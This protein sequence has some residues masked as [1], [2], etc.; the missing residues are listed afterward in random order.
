MVASRTLTDPTSNPSPTPSSAPAGG[1]ARSRTRYRPK[2]KTRWQRIPFL[3]RLLVP[4]GVVSAAMWGFDRYRSSHAWLTFHRPDGR[5]VPALELTFF[6]DAMSFAAPSPRPP[7]GAA[8][9]AAGADAVVVGSDLVPGTALV[10][11][12]GEG[13][14][15]GYTSVGIGAD[16]AIELKPPATLPGRVGEPS[17]AY[18]FGWRSFGLRPIADAAVLG[19][20]GGEHGV[21]LVE[22]R[23]DAEGRF[24]LRGFDASMVTLGVRVL[25][26]GY[27]MSWQE[28]DWSRPGGP[29]IAL[30]PTTPIRGRLRLPA[31]LPTDALQLLARG[32]P[33]VATTI[34][35][36]GA[37]ALDH[38]PPGLEPKL[39]VH[40]LPDTWT[41]LESRGKVGGA[42]LEIPIL[43]AGVVRGY[44]I[45]LT[46]QRP[47]A[48]AVVWHRHGPT[49]MTVARS[50]AQG[51]FTIG[52]IP[53]GELTLGAHWEESRPGRKT[54]SLAGQRVFEVSEG[55]QIADVIIRVE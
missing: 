12:R 25:K 6:P 8:A 46:S 4:L 26:P 28:W 37:F 34:A 49:G 22:T 19:F 20:G 7:F 21:P 10:R 39:L 2:P 30:V 52:R 54:L 16:C 33:G 31:E 40:G 27:A 29:V 9:L 14:G 36:D 5:P 42:P 47:L 23:T 15:T 45:D 18:V 38:V 32:L 44:V 13:I 48:G 35:P 17:Q 3:V 55:Q 53:P 41:H 11:Y 50:D 51:A 43:R 24:E 1:Q